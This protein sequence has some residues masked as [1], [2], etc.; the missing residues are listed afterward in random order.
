MYGACKR[1]F[2]DLRA[3]QWWISYNMNSRKRLAVTNKSTSQLEVPNT[4]KDIPKHPWALM[5]QLGNVETKIT[6]R[7][8]CNDHLRLIVQWLQKSLTH[9]DSWQP[10]QEPT[11]F[12]DDI[13]LLS[14]S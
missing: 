14:R 9:L 11:R 1:L 3:E 8:A 5:E 13:A 6:T 12:G 2:V 10:Q 7:I 4:S